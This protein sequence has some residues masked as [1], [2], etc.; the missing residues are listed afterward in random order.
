MQKLKIA[1]F[2]VFLTIS[3]SFSQDS[4]SNNET[5]F[6][7]QIGYFSFST[8]NSHNGAAEIRPSFHQKYSRTF[9]LVA[10]I[11][12]SREK[13]GNSYSSQNLFALG[14]KFKP[15]VNEGFYMKPGMGLFIAGGDNDRHIIPTLD[16]GFGHDFR[17]SNKFDVF[18]EAEGYLVFPF[19]FAYSISAGS[20]FKFN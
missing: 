8:G 6:G 5:A 9:T 4:N 2:I 18:A 14:F 15:K 17:I 16:F 7:L 12:F 11:T 10:E 19:G 3:N 13:N 20:K 1:I